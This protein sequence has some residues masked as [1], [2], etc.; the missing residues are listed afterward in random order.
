[1]KKRQKPVQL[2]RETLRNFVPPPV[3]VDVLA[4][5]AGGI[6]KPSNYLDDT[7][8]LPYTAYDSEGC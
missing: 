6:R 5:V 1:M 8:E 4:L 7:T 2:H 3:P